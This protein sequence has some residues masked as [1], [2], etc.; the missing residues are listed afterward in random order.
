M[1]DI[2]R[3]VVQKGATSLALLIALVSVV[4]VGMSLLVVL[5]LTGN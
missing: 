3:A 1:L 5:K 2:I 4:V